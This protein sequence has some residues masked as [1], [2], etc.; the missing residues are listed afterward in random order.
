MAKVRKQRRAE[1]ELRMQAAR[2]Q[3]AAR[4]A[5][6]LRRRELWR[7]VT[8]QKLRQRSS[9]RLFARR[10]P[11][12]RAFVGVLALLILVVI[13]SVVP[14]LALKVAL[15]LLFMLALPVLVIVAFDRRGS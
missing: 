8:L 13:W 9:G 14:S 3:E 15:S 12:Q 6:R 7:R 4:A 11:G 2:E 5:K 10:S 1:R